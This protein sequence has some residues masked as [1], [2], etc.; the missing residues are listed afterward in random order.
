MPQIPL[1]ERRVAPT[2][3]APAVT[4]EANLAPF[5]AIAQLGGQI[6]DIS[7]DYSERKNKLKEQADS[8]DYQTRKRNLQTTLIQAKNDALQSG[9]SY[10]D[11]YEKVYQPALDAFEK[12]NGGRGYSR[13]SMERIGQEW[14]FDRAGFEQKEINEREQLEL[15]DYILRIDQEA[16]ALISSGNEE[17]IAQG[18]AMYD[19]LS[20]IVGDGTVEEMKSGAWYKT[21]ILDLQEIERQRID[22][23]IDDEEYFDKLDAFQNNIKN[24]KYLA[25]HTTTI[26]AQINSKKLNTKG[27]FVKGRDSAIRDFRA[28][29]KKDK[30]TGDD[31]LRLEQV[32]G[33][34]WADSFR[35][36]IKNAVSVE[37]TT[38][39]DTDKVYNAVLDY[40][41]G[42]TSA[43]KALYIIDGVNG[44]YSEM[45]VWLV[46]QIA[47]D[48]AAN[49]GVVVAYDADR[50]GVP[51]KVTSDTTDFVE[52]LGNYLVQQDDGEKARYFAYKF[53][54]YDKWR[55]ENPNHTRDEYISWRNELFKTD[56]ENFVQ[57]I[58]APQSTTLGISAGTI[59]DGYEFTGGDPSDPANWREM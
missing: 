32:A 41:N 24:N 23:E 29:R 59:E 12:D 7:A 36:A 20:G 19:D 45:G 16:Q 50:N 38:D 28:L 15:N 49:N 46:A 52:I 51:S 58:N 17:Q 54:A 6:A 55:E 21:A 47:E 33:K 5:R 34:K 57:K 22:E 9:T 10:Q 11:I 30:V 53:N 18:N 3:Q 2:T 14:Q 35:N 37:A 56:S 48:Q 1:V 39:K 40:Q 31:L 43:A 44:Q 42:K 27:M 8:A 25:K 4:G 13:S 26:D